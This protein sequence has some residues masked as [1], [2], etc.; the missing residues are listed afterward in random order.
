MGRQIDVNNAGGLDTRLSSVDVPGNSGSEI[1]DNFIFFLH[2]VQP[3]PLA[4]CFVRS[5]P[6]VGE[7]FLVVL[8]MA[9]ATSENG[10]SLSQPRLGD[11]Q[12]EQL[13][14]AMTSP[15]FPERSLV[16]SAQNQLGPKLTRPWITRSF[17]LLL[18]PLFF[19]LLL[20]SFVLCTGNLFHLK[21]CQ[22]KKFGNLERCNFQTVTVMYCLEWE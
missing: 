21:E 9:M 11:L 6:F 18:V 3:L 1:C 22:F 17:S 8:A 4:Y 20:P 13:H 7:K 10:F 16:N 19:F 14:Q 2:L 15:A 5:G 12:L